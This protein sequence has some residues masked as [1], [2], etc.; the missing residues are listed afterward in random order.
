LASPLPRRGEGQGEGLERPR[1][2]ARAK[3]SA[4]AV[5]AL[6]STEPE[7]AAAAET[8][9][10]EEVPAPLTP[11][12]SPTGGEGA[13]PPPFDVS[14]LH[15]ALADSARRCY[16]PAAKRFHLTGEA[17]VDFCLDA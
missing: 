5:V 3:T 8:A 15:A 6:P 14:A 4:P 16:P 12:L 7:I 17:Q 10:P 9:T 1:R 11:T 13:P 2:A